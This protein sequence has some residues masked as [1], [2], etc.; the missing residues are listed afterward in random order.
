MMNLNK[1][2]IIIKKDLNI[3]SKKTPK[4]NFQDVVWF[5]NISEK[6]SLKILWTFCSNKSLF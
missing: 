4:L 3:P 1:D 2:L 6:K 5:S